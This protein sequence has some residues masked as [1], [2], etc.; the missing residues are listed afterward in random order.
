MWLLVRR[1]AVITF[2]PTL[3]LFGG[4]LAAL[5]F[6]FFIGTISAVAFLAAC[7]VLLAARPS[8]LL[9][10]GRDAWLV[11]LLA[12]WCILSV[13]WSEAPSAT[14]RFSIQLALTFA[15][16]IAAASRL[17]LTSVL[18]AALV[19]ALVVGVASV[20]F[21]RVNAG[22]FWVGIF[23]SKNALAQFSALAVIVSSAILIDRRGR[24][25]GWIAMALVVA[26][27]ALLL[28]SR[29][30]SLGASLAAV[31]TFLAMLSLWL[32]RRATGW[33]RVF[34]ASLMTLGALLIVAILIG[35]FEQASAYFLQAT[36]KDF[37]LTGRTEL[38][39]VAFR[40][41][42]DSPLLGHGYRGFWVPGNPVAEE[43]WAEF[44]IASKTGFHF[45]NTLIS[46]AVEI[47]LV[48][49]ALQAIVFFGTLVAALRWAL[50]NPCAEALLLAGFM[51]R[52]TAL[53]NS[54]VVF[55]TQFE[56]GSVLLVMAAVYAR[57][58]RQNVFPKAARVFPR[59]VL[60]PM[61]PLHGRF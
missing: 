55:F 57:R 46:N 1:G 6:T 54:E 61:S 3:L 29:A 16:G 5:H 21:G 35:T 18:H 59:V 49:V 15:F 52:Q 48:G 20:L 51:V 38:W 47:G 31:I 2:N 43:L 53:M 13:L 44:D 7:L 25:R 17:S 27:I 26:L 11:V 37:T 50:I 23:G 40:E 32:L 58:L 33:Q 41:I 12:L 39:A 42:T 34:L 28:L 45:H 24:G 4:G 10:E 19:V 14:L 60:S 36:G 8:G 56:P 30:G 22:G 9:Q